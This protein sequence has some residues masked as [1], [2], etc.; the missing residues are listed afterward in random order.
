MVRDEIWSLLV[1]VVSRLDLFGLMFRSNLAW[2]V[3]S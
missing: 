2:Q 3:P 1:T